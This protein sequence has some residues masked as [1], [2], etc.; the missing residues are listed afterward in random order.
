MK[1]FIFVSLEIIL[2]VSSVGE[3]PNIQ[4]HVGIPTKV[5]RKGKYKHANFM[6][7]LLI[8]V[9]LPREEITVAASLHTL[10]IELKF[11]AKCQL[12]WLV[13]LISRKK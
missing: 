2:N 8:V 9:E 10:L 3:A 11:I 6:F 1:S 4:L 12:S 7:V 13:P 5:K